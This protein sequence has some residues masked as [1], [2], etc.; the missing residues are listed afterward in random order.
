MN[1]S[2]VSSAINPNNQVEKVS[3]QARFQSD[4]NTPKGQSEII[5]HSPVGNRGLKT[6][7]SSAP[8][9]KFGIV[10]AHTGSTQKRI[11]FK[12]GQAIKDPNHGLGIY[13]GTFQNVELPDLKAVGKAIAS[14]QPNQALTLGVAALSHTY[15]LET[16]KAYTERLD[17]LSLLNEGD[18]IDGM[19]QSEYASQF[20][21]RTKKLIKQPTD[22]AGLIL[23]DHDPEPGKQDLN[24]SEFRARLVEL[25]PELAPVAYLQTTSSSSG[26]YLKE[27]GECLKPETGHHTLKAVTGDQT[28]L[29]RLLDVRGWATGTSFF[30]LAKA[31]EATGVAAVLERHLVDMA[32]F[33]PER[34]VY[35]AGACFEPDSPLEQRRTEPKYY[36][37]AIAALNCDELPDPTAE[38]LAAAAANRAAALEA[39]GKRQQK[40]A[41]NH[42][43][44]A[45][46]KGRYPNPERE[47]KRRITAQSKGELA[48][49][50][51][52]HCTDGRTILVSEL[53]PEHD[54]LTFADPQEPD[55]DG[56]SQKAIFYWNDGKGWR[57]HSQ[58]HGGTVYRKADRP[59]AAK[60]RKQQLG[61]LR[62]K[63]LRATALPAL[64]SSNPYAEPR[65]R[66][67]NLKPGEVTAISAATGT[68][69]T[70]QIKASEMS[71]REAAAARGAVHNTVVLTYRV[72]LSL[73]TGD[74]LGLP[75]S[76]ELSLPDGTPN[77]VQIEQAY[78][79]ERAGLSACV[80]SVSK[81]HTFVRDARKRGEAVSVLLDE[82]HA[83]A[84]SLLLSS[85]INGQNGTT[86]SDVIDMT[87]KAI[88]LAVESGGNVYLAE[89]QNTELAVNYFADLCRFD[90]SSII[91]HVNEGLPRPN[92][93]IKF[94][95]AESKKGGYA[96]N[97]LKKAASV[98]VDELGSAKKNLLLT[99]DSATWAALMAEHLEHNHDYVVVLVDRFTKADKKDFLR[100][101]EKYIKA[102][103]AAHPGRPVAV[104]I[105]PTVESGSHLGSGLFDQGVA[106][107]CGKIGTRA[108]Y[109][110]MQRDRS[111]MP[112]D[113][114][115]PI[116]TMKG[117][118]YDESDLELDAIKQEFVELA[119]IGAI[120]ATGTDKIST[121]YT[122]DT[123]EAKVSKHYAAC[124][125]QQQRIDDCD[126]RG[127][128]LAMCE[129]SGFTIDEGV[130][131]PGMAASVESIQQ[132]KER[133]DK[134]K[135]DL[136]LSANVSDMSLKEA[137][138]LAK[139]ELPVVDGSVLLASSGKKIPLIAAH[140]L[141]DKVRTAH[142]YPG[143]P[144]NNE[145]F[146]LE[147]FIQKGGRE[148]K[149]YRTLFYT[150]NS[151]IAT[152]IDRPDYDQASRS[153]WVADGH[154]M[155]RTS[156][157][158][159]YVQDSGVLDLLDG[160]PHGNQT[161]AKIA[162]FKYVTENATVHRALFGMNPLG[163]CTDD[164]TR[165]VNDVV[166]DFIRALGLK[167][168]PSHREGKRGDKSERFYLT[169]APDHA[170]EVWDAL[171]RKW[172][173]EF[174]EAEK[175]QE[176]WALGERSKAVAAK[177]DKDRVFIFGGNGHI[178]ESISG[179]AA[180][181][182]APPNPQ[183]GEGR[184][185]DELQLTLT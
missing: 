51:V 22:S 179:E 170:Y 74:D 146:S 15:R 66:P 34:L 126:Y 121:A 137:A 82:S 118:T 86:R 25:L 59:C 169:S 28:R 24:A 71:L 173:A 123:Y 152:Q 94:I 65:T 79:K 6:K 172:E 63:E 154:R 68:G 99:T 37:G 105:T 1:N 40:K 97:L 185:Q 41:V 85:T 36:E 132:S 110:M 160:T 53:G 12:D 156:A 124:F 2:K 70:H 134:R 107:F 88:R 171:Q 78:Y 35:E 14:I 104:I 138:Q 93:V 159:K 181:Q 103:K 139:G 62:A 180:A 47:A 33:S 166:N 87:A 141:A 125:V 147:H 32:V 61:N 127:G 143:L 117:F 30:K 5:P 75:Q 48:P 3:G 150:L 10:T 174:P 131:C 116:I 95:E 106:Y 111:D 23:F 19:S 98:R 56:G 144:Q 20:I 161:P 108:A 8:G 43:L 29:T 42:I 52:L 157:K 168:E 13:S 90:R 151:E 54:R 84:A 101:P 130:I 153:I 177:L 148:L 162:V 72:S 81:V 45:E 18:R 149:K 46:P 176:Y 119:R 80:E 183:I 17:R 11:L 83:L 44:K 69:K 27:T 122:T 21:S 115:T 136:R 163:S 167:A 129:Q 39:I 38:E 92:K 26:I 164:D 158:A 120:A 64:T 73:E 57:I 178:S 91:R 89:H 142:E 145:D 49:E 128:L 165:S 182:N 31:N 133:L 58:A 16:N 102:V 175:P 112:W 60:P 155:G 109:Q 114:F 76:H 140:L 50:H 100:A 184:S 67:L 7:P 113:V 96:D 55:Y 135:N 4:S 9:I 77:R